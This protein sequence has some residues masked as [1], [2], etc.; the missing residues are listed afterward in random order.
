VAKSNQLKTSLSVT[1]LID[2]K[3]WDNRLDQLPAVT[4]Y[5][6]LPEKVDLSIYRG[7]MIDLPGEYWLYIGYRLELS[8]PPY[9]FSIINLKF[10][11][12]NSTPK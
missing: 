2:P 3:H 8:H 10:S 9:Q 6:A 12:L 5:Q 7:N 11:F 4:H 1:I